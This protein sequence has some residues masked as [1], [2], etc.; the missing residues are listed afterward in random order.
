MSSYDPPGFLEPQPPAAPAVLERLER[1]R[2]GAETMRVPIRDDSGR[3][4]GRLE[5]VTW[6]HAADDTLV[7]T[8]VR[9][10][11]QNREGW[12][13]QRPVSF[14]GTK[15]W[16]TAMLAAPDRLLTLFYWNETLI[17]RT[18]FVALG[19]DRYLTDGLVRGERG[20]GRDFLYWTSLANAKNEFEITGVKEFYVKI[21]SSNELAIQNSD[22]L[23][24]E[25]VTAVPVYK[26]ESEAGVEILEHGEKQQLIP[27][28]LLVYRRL[29]RVAFDR[30][31]DQ[32]YSR[33]GGS[34]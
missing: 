27:G 6:K 15:K 12:L 18:G 28:V 16:L 11:N 21:L 32:Y 14:E 34:T 24:L 29:T 13:D 23:G 25:T 26:H 1:L 17:G 8:F 2:T 3:P 7:E 9:W 31:F 20:G 22:R 4:V 5:P 33:R 10:R 30:V 19:A